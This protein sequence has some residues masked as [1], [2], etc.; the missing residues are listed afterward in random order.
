[1]LLYF[2]GA[3]SSSWD[4][5]GESS[6]RLCPRSDT[7][8]LIFYWEFSFE[9]P[10]TQQLMMSGTY[11]SVGVQ[12]SPLFARN[13]NGDSLVF[14]DLTGLY[15]TSG[16]YDIRFNSSDNNFFAEVPIEYGKI[17]VIYCSYL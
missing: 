14:H 5:D 6:R 12:L 9:D 1:M 4:I 15:N 11:C 7:V 3:P 16:E 8:D 17:V 13:N 10:L 2:V